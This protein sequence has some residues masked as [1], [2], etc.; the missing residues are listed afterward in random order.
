M[1]FS[2]LREYRLTVILLIALV[3]RLYHI[4]FPVG[5]FQAW[6]QADTAAMAR[7]FYENGFNFLYPQIDWGGNTPGYVETEFPAYSFLVALLYSIFGQSDVWGRLLSVLFA[8][9]TIYFLF[10]LVTIISG[11]KVAL[12]TASIY[13]ILPLNVFYTRAFM[14]ESAMLMCSVLGVYYFVQWLDTG[15]KRYWLGSLVF[16]SLAAL[17]KIPTLY[18]G[19]PLFF[20]AWQRYRLGILRNPRLWAFCMLVLGFVA[21]W[22][23]HAHHIYIQSGLSFGI[24]FFGE[25]KWGIG[26]PLLTFKFYND[27]FFKSIAERHL[28]YAGFIP[29]VIGLFLPRTSERERL[30]DWWLVALLVFF[31]VVTVG[32]QVHE[33]YQLPFVIPAVVY[34]AKTFHYFFSSGKLVEY[35]SRKRGMVI[36]LSLCLIAFPILSFLRVQNFMKGERLDSSLFKLAA[37]VKTSTSPGDLVIAVD[38]GDPLLLYQSARK[39]WHSWPCGLNHESVLARA[40]LGA[41]YLIAD[42]QS[43]RDDGCESS[44]DSLLTKYAIVQNTDTYLIVRL[45][46]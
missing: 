16:I 11:E 31:A 14:P 21:L 37:A 23:Y 39:G 5:G 40:R 45:D 36:A 35:W 44:I 6:R 13:A 30:F 34:V 26:S 32:N 22:Y 4:D 7:N 46:H 10:R 42:K 20:L 24:W 28:T 9:A 3:V 38:R 43:F 1:N 33:Y 12:W 25:D 27:V 41:K 18:L 8:L 17:L 15:K 2:L 19:L 29:F